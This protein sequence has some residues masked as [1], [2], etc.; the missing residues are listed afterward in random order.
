MR[1]AGG[2]TPRTFRL[3]ARLREGQFRT[4]TGFRRLFSALWK[5][6]RSRRICSHGNRALASPTRRRRAINHVY[7]EEAS[8]AAYFP[9]GRRRHN[10]LALTRSDDSGGDGISTN[11]RNTAAPFYRNFL[12]SRIGVLALGDAR[13]PAWRQVVV[14]HGAADSGEGPYCDSRR[15]LV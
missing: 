6:T 14:H 4:R 1:W 8:A 15:P 12:P 7:Y 5:A 9:E 11:S 3:C 10:G 2:L 13:R